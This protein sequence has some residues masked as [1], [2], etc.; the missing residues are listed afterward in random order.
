[1]AAAGI[2]LVQLI[3][4]QVVDNGSSAVPTDSAKPQCGG[5]GLDPSLGFN[6]QLHIG[7]LFIILVTSTLGMA[8]LCLTGLIV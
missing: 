7:A 1:M 3:G 5:G 6:V 2:S 4:R 8:R